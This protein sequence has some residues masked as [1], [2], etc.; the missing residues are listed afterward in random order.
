MKSCDVLREAV[1]RVGV[2]ALAA[3]LKVSSALVYK[4]CQA[5]S[6]DEPAGSGARNPLDRVRL[7]CEVTG[8]VRVVNWLCQAVGGFFVRNPAVAPGPIEAQLLGTTQRMVEDFGNLLAAVSGSI[9][10][11]G[12]ITRAEADHIRQKWEELKMQAESFIVA[13][14]RGMY[15]AP[16]ASR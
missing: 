12:K 8:D 4:W 1:E 3:R 6:D 7:I 11:D 16:V 13:C 5:T 15:A 9:E 14:E 2:K 10:N